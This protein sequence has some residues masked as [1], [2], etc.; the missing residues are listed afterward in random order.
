MINKRINL[1]KIRDEIDYKKAMHV[2]LSKAY[3]QSVLPNRDVRGSILKI[4]HGRIHIIYYDKKPFEL[5]E[6][7]YEFDLP[8]GGV[9]Q[10]S[11][12]MWNRHIAEL[13]FSE[14][15]TWVSKH[16][17]KLNSNL[18]S[19]T[20]DLILDAEKKILYYETEKYPV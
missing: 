9:F 6:D 1:S 14:F 4:E 3:G 16:A 2:E 20:I 8:D 18:L 17:D 11:K 7:G 15:T 12:E 19:Y 13:N 10:L 5:D